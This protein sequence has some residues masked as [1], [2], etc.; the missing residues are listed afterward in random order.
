[1]TKMNKSRIWLN[2]PELNAFLVFVG[3]PLFT[4]IV[5]GHEETDVEFGSSGSRLSIIYRI[6]CL[7]LSIYLIFSNRIGFKNN[8]FN[9]NLKMTF[10]L[11]MLMAIK[12][13]YSLFLAPYSSLWTSDLI[14]TRLSFLFGVTLFPV[15]AIAITFNKINWEKIFI[16]ISFTLLFLCIDTLIFSTGLDGRIDLNGHQSTLAFG[17]YSAYLLIISLCFFN[18]KG[19]KVMMK[20]LIPIMIIVGFYGLLRA[21]SRGP[22]ISA[23][24]SI[25]PIFLLKKGN[26]GFFV[27][28]LFMILIF[29]SMIMSQLESIAPVIFERFSDA[30]NKDES[31]TERI[32]A[33]NLAWEQLNNYPLTGESPI[34]Y[35]D[36]AY[37]YGPHNLPLQVAMGLG[38]IGFIWICILYFNYMKRALYSFNRGIIPSIFASLTIYFLIRTQTGVDI[39]SASDFGFVLVG[40]YMTTEKNYIEKSL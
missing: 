37:G 31:T 35:T 18:Q 17:A 5:Y 28:I 4:Q 11:F 9:R 2:L 8:R 30:L 1:M 3:F 40:L 27:I 21:G 24:I 39:Y 10:I 26:R 13:C 38:Y 32:I 25:L 12:L 19:M 16:Y 15:L 22:L 23:V 29:G 6:V 20:L 36:W 7:A 34:F 14:F 33:F